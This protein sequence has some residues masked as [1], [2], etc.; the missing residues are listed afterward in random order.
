MFAIFRENKNRNMPQEKGGRNKGGR[1]K[2]GR[3]KGGR[4]K[5]GN[6]GVNKGG[7]N[8]GG[9]NY[10]GDL[11]VV[12]RTEPPKD[13]DFKKRFKTLFRRDMQEFLECIEYFILYYTFIV[14]WYP[15]FLVDAQ[16]IVDLYDNFNILD[17]RDFED[18]VLHL[19]T[20][21]HHF[22]TNIFYILREIPLSC[23]KCEDCSHYSFCEECFRTI[24]KTCL[25][26]QGILC[27]LD[28]AKNKKFDLEV[29]K[30]IFEA[31]QRVQSPDYGVGTYC[32]T[33]LIVGMELFV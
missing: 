1:N 19:F 25:L 3:N 23:L 15:T 10:R 28:Q 22:D 30:G 20:K 13:P 26:D 9:R 21:L 32:E 12:L 2:G 24:E 4:N 18:D 7:R 5:G 31:K 11:H 29:Q 17:F 8:K 27:F 14:L 16:E 6:K 33:N